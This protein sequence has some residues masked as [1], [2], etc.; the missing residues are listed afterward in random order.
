[1][2]MHGG[3]TTMLDRPPST[4]AEAL[5]IGGMDWE[6]IEKPSAHL[7]LQNNIVL[8]PDYKA[9]LRS[10]TGNL[11]EVVPKTWEVLQNSQAF[12]L[13]QPLIDQGVFELQTGLTIGNRAILTGKVTHSKGDVVPGDKVENYLMISNPNVY[14][15]SVEVAFIPKRLFCAN[16]LG[17][18]QKTISKTH[19]HGRSMAIGDKVARLRHT[20]SLHDNLEMLSDLIQ[21]EK[22]SFDVALY[23]YGLMSKI[24]IT[25][26]QLVEVYGKAFQVPMEEV[27]THPHYD[28]IV[29]NFENGI[30]INH[31]GVSGTGW[32]AYNAITE[33]TTHQRTSRGATEGDKEISRLNSLYFGASAKITERAHSAILQLA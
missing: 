31:P 21:V 19:Y 11:I 32:A 7:D 4:I 16:M 22:A 15:K 30:G 33:F 28:R 14:G 20:A 8:S 9:L 23:E 6:T 24:Q 26:T 2:P 12:R 18:I 3:I 27:E 29:N 10:D 17:N 1:M 25:S 13:F 5:A